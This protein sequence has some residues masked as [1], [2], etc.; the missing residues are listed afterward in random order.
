MDN[1]IAVVAAILYLLA[2]ATIVPGLVHQTGI[3]VKTVFVSAFIALAFHAW[4]LSDLILGSSGQN[5][6]ILN[7]ASLISFIVS[8]VMSGAML[9]TRLWFL[10]PVVYS[11]A[12][13]NLMAAAFLPST[14]ITHLE[15]DPKLLI[16]ISFA[17]FSYSTLT[18]GA[19]YALQLAWLDHK[20]KAKKAL[21]INP[22]LP[23]LLM[24][25]RQLFN[26]ILIGNL[27]LTGTLL[28]G[29]VFV[30]DMFAQGKA[31]KGI[32]SFIAWIVYSVLLWGHYRK[33]WRGRKVT[34]FAVAGATLLT[35]AY[36]GSRFVREII[37]N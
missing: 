16:H 8:L 11:F 34:W 5:L 13:L 3:R 27:L 7:V 33:G 30:Q 1:L 20:L 28:T 17:L 10:L 35:L 12:A 21:A 2:I 29:F 19:L 26:I 31:H 6:S 24:V 4:L 37:L 25:E 23:P 9:K 22:N 15:Q 14:F 32:L 36:F 18:I